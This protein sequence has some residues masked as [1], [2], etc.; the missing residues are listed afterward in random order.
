MIELAVVIT[1]FLMLVGVLNRTE[2]SPEGAGISR[3][4]VRVY[5]G[6]GDRNDS[7]AD[8][9]KRQVKPI[10]QTEEGRRS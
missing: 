2:L 9:C 5:R 10:W 4:R 6:A 8:D 1:L 7:F 3:R